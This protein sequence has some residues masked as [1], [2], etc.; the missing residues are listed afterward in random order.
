MTL[1]FMYRF[2]SGVTASQNPIIP[3]YSRV[4]VGSLGVISFTPWLKQQQGPCPAELWI[5]P[6]LEI[7]QPLWKTCS[8]IELS[9]G[10]KNFFAPNWEFSCWN[11][12]LFLLVLLLLA[13]K[14]GQVNFLCSKVRS[15]TEKLIHVPVLMR[16]K[17]PVILPGKDFLRL[18]LKPSVIQ[19]T[20]FR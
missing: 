12:C 7:L 13:W 1:P 3:F 10:R 17:N 9:T 20:Q 16:T 2:N 11:S 18:S 14:K 6:N 4:S 5:L 15:F 8:N 19:M